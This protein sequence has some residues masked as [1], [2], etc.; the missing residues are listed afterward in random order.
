MSPH[1]KYII[2]AQVKFVNDHVSLPLL[3][4]DMFVPKSRCTESCCG[5]WGV[6]ESVITAQQS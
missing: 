1:S 6:W 4:H 5:D 3:K 2:V